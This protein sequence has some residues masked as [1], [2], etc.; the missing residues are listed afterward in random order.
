MV[1]PGVITVD[2]NLLSKMWCCFVSNAFFPPVAFMIFSYIPKILQFY[3][4][5]Q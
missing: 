2:E 1:V 3:L 5:A 4:F